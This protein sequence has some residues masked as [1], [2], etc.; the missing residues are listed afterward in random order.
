[1]TKIETAQD[2][3]D[4]LIDL[5]ESGEIDDEHGFNGIKSSMTFDAAM[6][7]TSDTGVVVRMTDGAEYQLAIVQSRKAGT[8]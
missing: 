5:F 2:F 4:S 1:M 3:A 8:K 6:L 7:L